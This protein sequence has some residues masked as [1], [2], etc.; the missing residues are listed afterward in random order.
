MTK[1]RR[2]KWA[3]AT[4]QKHLE[5]PNNVGNSIEPHAEGILFGG[6]IMDIENKKCSHSTNGS[7]IVFFHSSQGRKNY[8]KYWSAH[9]NNQKNNGIDIEYERNLTMH[10]LEPNSYHSVLHVVHAQGSLS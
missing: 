3:Q 5:I 2:S 7:Y 1:Y 10:K 4:C 9:E 8:T 6:S